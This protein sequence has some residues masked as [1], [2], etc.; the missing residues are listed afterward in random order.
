MATK[1][2]RK[3]KKKRA[4]TATKELDLSHATVLRALLTR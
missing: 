4:A 1:E 2:A 3:T